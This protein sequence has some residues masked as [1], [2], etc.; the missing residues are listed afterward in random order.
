MLTFLVPVDGSDF[1]DRAVRYVIKR[2][3]AVARSASVHLLN[4]QTPAVG[5]NVKI[6]VSAESLQ[7]Y[8]REEGMKIVQPAYDVLVRAGVPAEYHI[9][10]GDVGTV[11]IEY[12]AEKRCDEVVMGTHGRGG[13]LNAVL[14]SAAQKVVQLAPIPVV[15]IK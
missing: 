15:L 4:V 2:A 7:S 11:I 5:V 8:Y 10:V 13:L 1:S 9:G 12:A 6:F 3:E 14:G